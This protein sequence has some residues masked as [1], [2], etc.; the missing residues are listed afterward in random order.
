MSEPVLRA[1][2]LSKRFGR[3]WALEN[4]SFEVQPGE[5]VGVVGRRASGKSTLLHVVAG[6]YPPQ[7]G[8]VW[9]GDLRLRSHGRQP[10]HPG[11]AGHNMPLRLQR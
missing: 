6:T 3:L 1:V 8:E 7:T 11:A 2:N 5:V 10:G 9:L 4:V